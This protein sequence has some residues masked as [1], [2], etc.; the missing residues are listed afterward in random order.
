MR[1]SRNSVGAAL[2][3]LLAGT[4]VVL[5]W[6]VYE[7][8]RLAGLPSMEIAPVVAA[9]DPLEPL[10]APGSFE[11][12]PIGEFQVVIERTLF[13]PT[14]RPAVPGEE[15]P[16]ATAPPA[17]LDLVLTGIVGA[18]DTRVAILTTLS[19]RETIQLAPGDSYQGW[20][21]SQMSSRTIV[22]SLGGRTAE[23]ALDYEHSPKRGQGQP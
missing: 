17:L 4:C 15:D 9:P 20:T 2:P 16:E 10:P 7:E 19:G 8:A 18:A 23:I 12:A 22:F 3:I 14:R 6:T 13:S 1:R 21:V 5:G 11:L